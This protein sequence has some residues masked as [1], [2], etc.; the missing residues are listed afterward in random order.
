MSLAQL[1]PASELFSKAEIRIVAMTVMIETIKRVR[2]L[3]I[4]IIQ[5][6]KTHKKEI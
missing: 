3:L 4:T 1:R 5:A 2:V 6:I